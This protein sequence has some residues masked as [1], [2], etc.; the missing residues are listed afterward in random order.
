MD[1]FGIYNVHSVVHTIRMFYKS[2]LH[3][4]SIIMYTHLRTEFVPLA[5][6]GMYRTA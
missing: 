4:M 3:V 1:E 5:F 2:I 6:L